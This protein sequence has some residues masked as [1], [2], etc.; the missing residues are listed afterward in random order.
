MTE[1]PALVTRGSG[2]TTLVFLHGVGGG[3]G[4][5]SEQLDWF[6][7]WGYRAV[8]WDMPGYGE[9]AM[10]S[11]YTIANLAESLVRLIDSLGVTR[12]VVVGHSMGGMVAQEAIG[13]APERVVGLVLSGTSPAFGKAEGDWQRDFL[14][15]RLAP[16]D[17]GRTMAEVAAKLVPTML[18]EGADPKGVAAALALMSAVPAST[19]RAALTALMGFDRREWLARLAVPTLVLAGE[20]DANAP[21]SVMRRMAEKIRGAEYVELAGLGH[22]AN[23]EHPA[24]FN[25]AVL[26]YL[27]KHFP[28]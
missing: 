10:A 15:A 1:V 27:A 11:P 9:S 4:A 22:L 8:A 14:A 21:P 17:A 5:W 28:T 20:R 25:A 24:S 12:T 2:A 13:I 23:M 19:Y 16:L 6:A 26:A 18:G 7:A 3:K